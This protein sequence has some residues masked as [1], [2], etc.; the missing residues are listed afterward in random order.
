MRCQMARRRYIPAGAIRSIKNNSEAKA[1][2]WPAL[3]LGSGVVLTIAWI[4]TLGWAAT[5]LI[6]L[7]A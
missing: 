2:V 5:Y 1:K 6:A 4:A 7:V 3:L